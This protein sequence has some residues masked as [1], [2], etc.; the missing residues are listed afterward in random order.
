MAAVGFA[1]D[2][3][4][5][6]ERADLSGRGAADLVRRRGCSTTTGHDLLHDPQIRTCRS[7]PPGC[8]AATAI[9]GSA[10]GTLGGGGNPY[11]YPDN[12]PRVNAHGG[13]RAPGCW[14]DITRDLRPRRIW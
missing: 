1:N 8:S 5:S 11:V 6:F 4:D 9:V 13:P 7:G 14:Q 2:A 12:L 3:A 10:S